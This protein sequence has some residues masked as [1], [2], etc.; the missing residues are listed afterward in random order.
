MPA[1]MAHLGNSENRETVVLLTE[2]D[3]TRAQIAAP[4]VL[5]AWE[6]RDAYYWR[7]VHLGFLVGAA[8]LLVGC[9]ALQWSVAVVLVAIVLDVFRP[10]D[11]RFPEA[12]IG[13]RPGATGAG[14]C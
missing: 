10:V 7:R 12:T 4:H 2:L 11:L 1:D 9:V 14:S 6:A 3:V 13:L 8:V 5:A